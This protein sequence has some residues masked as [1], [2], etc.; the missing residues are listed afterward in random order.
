MAEIKIR[1]KRGTRLW[2]LL[3]V[4]LVPLV[5][6]FLRRRDAMESD[7]ARAARAPAAA[8]APAVRR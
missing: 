8:T 6:L 1:R 5:W 2:P 7:E 3:L 4:L